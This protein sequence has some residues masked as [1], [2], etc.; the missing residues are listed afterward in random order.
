MR[1][2][3]SSHF[4]LISLHHLA[5]INELAIWVWEV[6][7]L[8]NDSFQELRWFSSLLLCKNSEAIL[9]CLSLERLLQSGLSIGCSLVS[10]RSQ[11]RDH[12][13]SNAS[14]TTWCKRH[15]SLS[16]HLLLFLVYCYFSV[17]LPVTKQ[18]FHKCKLRGWWHSGLCTCRRNQLST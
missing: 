13:I 15:W 4:P 8:W 11:L 12:V 1:A 14:L 9:H 16:L 7:M 17:T 3:T 6:C 5:Q 10:F 18:V 2:L